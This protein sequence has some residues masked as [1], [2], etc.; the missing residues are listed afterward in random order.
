MTALEQATELQAQAVSI[1]LAERD[2]IDAR[3]RQ[4][5]YGENKNHVSKETWSSR[6]DQRDFFPSCNPR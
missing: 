3:L 2:A 4:L 1:L 5:G 6:Q